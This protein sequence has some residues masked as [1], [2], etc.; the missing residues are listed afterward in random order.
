MQMQCWTKDAVSAFFPSNALKKS[1]SSRCPC[2]CPPIETLHQTSFGCMLSPRVIEGTSEDAPTRTTT[3]SSAR[4]TGARQTAVCTSWGQ[5][6]G[7]IVYAP[8]MCTI[9]P[10]GGHAQGWESTTT[11]RKQKA[12]LAKDLEA[13]PKGSHADGFPTKSD[14]LIHSMLSTPTIRFPHIR[15]KLLDTGQRK[16]GGILFHLRS[17]SDPPTQPPHLWDPP[18]L[19]K[20]PPLGSRMP[21]SRVQGVHWAADG[22][23]C[24]HIHGKIVLRWRANCW[25]TLPV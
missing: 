9:S 22:A 4:V 3:I 17:F 25:K 19:P 21:L 14:I 20:M 24:I 16:P 6:K 13:T 23:H 18:H 10:G 8:P 2:P 12:C 5:G 1:E 7:C 11:Y 15:T